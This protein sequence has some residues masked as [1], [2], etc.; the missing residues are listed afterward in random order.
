VQSDSLRCSLEDRHYP[1]MQL[2]QC[3]LVAN[4]QIGSIM[5][6]FSDRCMAMAADGAVLVFHFHAELHGFRDALQQFPKGV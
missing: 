5:A 2:S 1:S 4:E 6:V 3:G